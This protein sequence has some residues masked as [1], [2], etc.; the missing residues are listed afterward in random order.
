MTETYNHFY[1]TYFKSKGSSGAI[2]NGSSTYTL[3]TME[4]LF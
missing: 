3:S 2:T 4:T 1:D